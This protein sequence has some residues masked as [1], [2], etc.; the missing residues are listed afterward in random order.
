MSLLKLGGVQRLTGPQWKVFGMSLRLD[1][2]LI[3]STVSLLVWQPPV[4]PNII[5]VI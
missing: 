5:L 3:H 4:G 1:A 2:P